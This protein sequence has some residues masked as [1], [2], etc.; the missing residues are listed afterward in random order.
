MSEYFQ[1]VANDVLKASEELSARM[2]DGL[3]A[4]MTGELPKAATEGSGAT[5]PPTADGFGE[6]DFEIEEEFMHSPLEGIAESV[7]GD[8][9]QNSVRYY[10]A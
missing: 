3:T 1:R 7:L 10:F 9:M 2:E 4:M 5:P 8:L 6:D